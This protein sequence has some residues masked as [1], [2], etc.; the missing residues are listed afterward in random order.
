MSGKFQIDLVFQ[1]SICVNNLEEV[2]Q[3]WKDLVEFDQTTLVR[4]CTKDFYDRGEFDG[5][6]YMGR[7]TEPWFIKYCRFD[8]GGIDLEIIEPL[9]KRPGNPYSDFLIQNG[10]RNGVH[11]IACKIHDRPAFLL[12][13]EELGIPPLQ[14]GTMGQPM[15]NG[16]KKDFY[17]FDLRDQLG[18]IME[19]GNLVVG[20]LSTSPLAGNPEGYT[21]N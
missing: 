18:F 20:P 5:A 1:V 16:E 9:D 19:A 17:F 11:H 21:G 8:L 13:M 6:N 7:E 14:K 4:R 15:P 12:K 10:G 3:N 2:L